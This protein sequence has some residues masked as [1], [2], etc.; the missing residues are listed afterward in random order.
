MAVVKYSGLGMSVIYSGTSNNYRVRGCNNQ[1][2]YRRVIRRVINLR[3]SPS[4]PSSC[5]HRF[6]H[7]VIF[8]RFPKFLIISFENIESISRLSR[9]P[10]PRRLNNDITHDKNCIVSGEKRLLQKTWFITFRSNDE[11]FLPS[12]SHVTPLFEILSD[13]D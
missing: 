9:P 1:R 2:W 10:L 11:N 6:R 5:D 13:L 7:F 3:T 4:C 8:S 12:P